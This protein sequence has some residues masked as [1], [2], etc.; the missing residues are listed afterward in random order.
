LR[1]LNAEDAYTIMVKPGMPHAPVKEALGMPTLPT[2]LSGNIVSR[3]QQGTG[4][5]TRKGN[6]RS[7][8]ASNIR[9]L[10]AR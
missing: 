8:I 1:D 10:A 2:R 3:P 6:D 4:V 5:G 9:L 7:L